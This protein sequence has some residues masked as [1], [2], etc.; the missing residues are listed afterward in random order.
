MNSSGSIRCKK[1]RA[2]EEERYIEGPVTRKKRTKSAPKK[3]SFVQENDED[4][5]EP[6]DSV[7]VQC[8]N[9]GEVTTTRHTQNTAHTASR[10]KDLVRRLRRDEKKNHGYFKGEVTDSFSSGMKKP[11]RRR[12]PDRKLTKT[13]LF[14]GDIGVRWV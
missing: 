6:F 12:N 8:S 9:K 7:P 11:S 1:V 2:M 4:I 13:P 14:F 5:S 10:H 3:R